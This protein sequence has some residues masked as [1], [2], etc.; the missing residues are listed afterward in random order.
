MQCVAKALLAS[1]L[2]S[3]AEPSQ[4]A[5]SV[6]ALSV[7]NSQLCLSLDPNSNECKPVDARKYP[8]VAGSRCLVGSFARITHCFG[9]TIAQNAFV[10]LDPFEIRYEEVFFPNGSRDLFSEDRIVASCR[11]AVIKNG[12]NT[13]ISGNE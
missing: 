4:S 6:C 7:Q 12:G 3:A 9:V 1:A 11:P 2:V 5:E 8:D 13:P 10:R